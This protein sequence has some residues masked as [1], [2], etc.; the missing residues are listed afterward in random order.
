MIPPQENP[1]PSKQVENA[2][3]RIENPI[4]RSLTQ[5]LLGAGLG[6]GITAYALVRQ[7]AREARLGTATS[8]SVPFPT[9]IMAGAL[10]GGLAALFLL[11]RAWI[12]YGIAQRKE[13]QQSV[14]WLHVL[15]FLVYLGAF[16]MLLIALAVGA[17]FIS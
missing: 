8:N 17:S 11:S 13:Q 15:L 2:I 1:H 12:K 3:L 16:V 4:L 9:M 5:L 7:R 14:W 10:F 6:A